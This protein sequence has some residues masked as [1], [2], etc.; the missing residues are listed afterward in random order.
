VYASNR[1]TLRHI[2]RYRPYV[3]ASHSDAVSDPSILID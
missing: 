1:R 3:R 2:A